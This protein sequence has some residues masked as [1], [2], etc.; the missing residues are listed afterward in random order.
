MTILADFQRWNRGN[1]I[2]TSM[3]MAICAM[4]P[5]IVNVKLV[6]ESNGLGNPSLGM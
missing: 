6:V 2:I 3:D 1:G 4:E 5:G